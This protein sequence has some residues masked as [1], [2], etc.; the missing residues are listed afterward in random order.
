MKFFSIISSISM[1]L[2]I[3]DKRS[4]MVLH[5]TDISFPGL[6]NYTRDAHFQFW[7]NV[8]LADVAEAEPTR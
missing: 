5:E 7:S 4:I 1:F 3:K 8:N 6:Q 2:Y